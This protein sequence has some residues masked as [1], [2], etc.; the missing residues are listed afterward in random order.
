MRARLSAVKYLLNNKKTAAVLISTFTLSF[1]VLYVIYALLV[2]T[3]VTFKSIMIDIPKKLTYVDLC[4]KSLGI[5][6]NDFDNEEDA[7]KT[8]NEARQDLADRLGKREGIEEVWYT[9]I[10]L[11]EINCV[12]GSQSVKV[13][14][15]EKEQIPVFL[16]HVGAKLSE[17]RLPQDPGDVLISRLSANNNKYEVGDWFFKD[18]FGETFKVCGILDAD[19]PVSVGL[20]RGYSNAGYYF[21]VLNDENTSDLTEVLKEEG[22]SVCEDDVLWDGP[23]Y[24]ESYQK[25]VVGLIDVVINTIMGVVLVVTGISLLVAYTSFLRNRVNEYC[26]YASI[27]YSKADIYGLMLRETLMVFAAGLLLGTCLS[28]LGGFLVKKLVLD[29]MGLA[30]MV[31]YPEQMFKISAV[32]VLLVGLIQIPGLVMI[33]RIKT[34]DAIED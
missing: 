28:I 15:L 8:I 21:V 10:I 33:G 26:L 27:G 11:D 19:I 31:L 25:E 23:K 32:F 20:P 22:I 24:R 13:P 1:L 30:G 17:G 9:Q 14:L 34:I 2:S 18:G 29:A 6:L 3:S 4:P 5:D 12:V 16:D 7:G